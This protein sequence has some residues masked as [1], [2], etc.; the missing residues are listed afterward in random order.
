M[1]EHFRYTLI[2]SVRSPAGLF[3][4]A[5]LLCCAVLCQP[6]HSQSTQLKSPNSQENRMKH[7]ALIFYATRTLTPEELQQRKVEIA[8]WAKQV[9]AMGISLDPRSFGQPTA[10]LSAQAGEVVSHESADGS[11]FS[12]IVFFDSP[13]A[14]RALDIAKAHPGLHYGATV[15]V[16]EWTSPLETA[17]T[18]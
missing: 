17:P 1:R 18:R 7:Y 4:F 2:P 14:E 6:V 10:S 9:E 16:R 15:V 11:T 5:L 12:N 8:A 13:S 3:W